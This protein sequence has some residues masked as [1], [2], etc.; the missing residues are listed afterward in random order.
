MTNLGMAYQDVWSIPLRVLSVLLQTEAD[1]RDE[2]V[3]AALKS[4]KRQ[5]GHATLEVGQFI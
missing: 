5:K 4:L 3:K 2:K 1:I